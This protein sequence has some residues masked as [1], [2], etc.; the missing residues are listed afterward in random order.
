MCVTYVLYMCNIFNMC[1][2]YIYIIKYTCV[3]LYVFY[4]KEV[5]LFLRAFPQIFSSKIEWGNY[6]KSSGIYSFFFINTNS[7]ENT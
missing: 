6:H 3:L 5:L 1:I 7:E 4:I 2:L